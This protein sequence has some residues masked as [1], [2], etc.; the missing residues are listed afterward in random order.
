MKGCFININ[1]RSH[2]EKKI[3]DKHIADKGLL[4]Q[5]YKD[6]QTSKSVLKCAKDLNRYASP[7]KM[8]GGKIS[9]DKDFQHHRT[10]GKCNLKPQSDT[11]VCLL[12]SLP[13]LQGKKK[14]P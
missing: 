1:E 6:S 11:I 3:F 13:F 5:I 4:S 2:R 12:E 9:T 8:R 14:P 7:E 10:S